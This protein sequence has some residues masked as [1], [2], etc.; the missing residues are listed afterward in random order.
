M[1]FNDGDFVQIEYTVWRAADDKVVFTTDKKEAEKGDIYNKDAN[2]G[3]Q[4]IIVGKDS[5][6]KG[7]D[8]T[9]KGMSVGET[10][11]IELEPK[12]AFG[13]RN[14]DLVRV[15]SQSDFR[16]MD[17]E[18]YPGLRVDLDGSVATVKSVT[19]GRVLVDSNHPL[20]GEKLKYTIK[21]VKKLENDQE[22]IAAI[23]DMHSLKP[24]SI[25][26]S[27]KTVTI[28]FGSDVEKN[29]DYFV[30]KSSMT[31]SLFR[32]MEKIEKVDIK[33][34]YSRSKETKTET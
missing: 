23:A 25:E 26:I 11:R 15:M 33:E 12:D 34:E 16:R 13:E 3:P 9:V 14:P 7:V 29:A 28:T 32:F 21:V 20:A 5:V 8:S 30:N 1:S 22:K 24:K 10:K 31:A 17:I 4:L 19:S 18:P 6:V 27:D 2:Y